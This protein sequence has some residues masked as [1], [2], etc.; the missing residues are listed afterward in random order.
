MIIT[1]LIGI[2]FSLLALLGC[3]GQVK[4]FVPADLS[5]VSPGM[6]RIILTRQSQVSSPGPYVFFDIGDHIKP[7]ALIGGRLGRAVIKINPVTIGHVELKESG[8]TFDTLV[9]ENKK[10]DFFFDLLWC[11]SKTIRAQSC[12]NSENIG[13]A[14]SC[15]K[16]FIAGD[17]ALVWDSGIALGTKGDFINSMG[18][19]F[20]EKALPADLLTYIKSFDMTPLKNDELE[21]VETLQGK[22]GFKIP[23]SEA[24]L[25]FTKTPRKTVLR[26]PKGGGSWSAVHK[27]VGV[28]DNRQIHR[29]VEVVGSLN[30]KTTVI[31]ERDPGTMRLGAVCENI[32]YGSVISPQNI[33]VAA[34]KTYYIDFQV[35]PGRGAF[36]TLVKTE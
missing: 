3:A 32:R 18:K 24:T 4:P 5:Q 19:A 8:T 26:K 31:W 30:P 14:Q 22:Q 21:K 27:H 23:N 1:K 10:I 6:A 34:G 33:H 15:D 35:K 7:N 29:N 9:K 25:A 28:I 11:D 2:I 20:G 13:C 17:I 36:W 16:G 12:G